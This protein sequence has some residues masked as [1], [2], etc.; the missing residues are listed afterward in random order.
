MTEN[1]IATMGDPV[2][3]VVE[4]DPA[5]DEHRAGPGPR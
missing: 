1:S 3:P 2:V 4:A 5:A